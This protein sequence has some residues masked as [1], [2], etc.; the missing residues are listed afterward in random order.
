MDYDNCRSLPAMFFELAAERGDRPFLWAKHGGAYRSMSWAEAARDGQ[1]AGARTGGARRR[2]P[3]TGSRS[4]P[5]TG[6]NGSIAD[7][8]IMSAGAITVPAYTTNTVDDHRHILGN[9]GARAV[10]VSTAGWRPRCRPRRRRCRASHGD[11]RHRAGIGPGARRCDVRRCEASARGA[12]PD[13][14]AGRVAALGPDDIAC[15]I[16]T[17]GTGGVPK[18][19]M[20]SHGNILANCHGAFRLLETLGLGDEVFLSRSCRCRIP[21]STPPG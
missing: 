17:S 8:A 15:I 12:E 9:S 1:P 5:R 14:I 20:T 16:Y 11:R 7:L 6:R 18:G 2:S 3:A 13:D 19:V 21:T 10:I 4:S